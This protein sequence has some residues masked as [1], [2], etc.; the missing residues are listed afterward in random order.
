VSTDAL[1]AALREL[2]LRC[3]VEARDR[4][5]VLIA[6]DDG[7]ALEAVR[8][9]RDALRLARAHG[10]TNLAL[11]VRGAPADHATVHRD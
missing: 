7:A 3:T 2:G 10:F 9:R 11:D 5:A 6:D 1:E 8:T 4:L